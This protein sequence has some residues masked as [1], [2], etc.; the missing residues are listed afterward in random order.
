MLRTSARWCIT[1]A[2]FGSSSEMWMPGT[3]VG[4]ARNGPPVGVPGFGSQLSS[5][6]RPPAMLM[7]IMRFCERDISAAIAGEVKR[8]KFGSTAAAPV[9]ASEPKKRRRLMRCSAVEQA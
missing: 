1:F 9:A 8:P 5:C 4:I 6:E 2:V 3:E 7:T